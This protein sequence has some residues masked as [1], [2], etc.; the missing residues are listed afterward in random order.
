MECELFYIVKKF[1]ENQVKINDA[2]AE[3]Y[4]VNDVL[5][6]DIESIYE[7]LSDQDDIN[8]NVA[9]I[10]SLMTERI[11][12]LENRLNKLEK[13]KRRNASNK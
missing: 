6:D 13:E 3:Q 9:S 7:E 10:L 1:I 5:H 11:N 8:S 12:D 4:N 2:V